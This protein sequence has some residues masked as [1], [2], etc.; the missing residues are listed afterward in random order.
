MGK[1]EMNDVPTP[2]ELR[3]WAR[4]LAQGQAMTDMLP[5]FIDAYEKLWRVMRTAQRVTKK[6]EDGGFDIIVNDS[7]LSPLERLD[8]ALE[9]MELGE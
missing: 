2:P 1:P 6:N 8:E 4:R 3:E 7:D 5:R 9:Q